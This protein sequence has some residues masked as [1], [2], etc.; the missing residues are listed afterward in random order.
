[1][2]I[3]TRPSPM[4]RK[5]F[6]PLSVPPLVTAMPQSRAESVPTCWRRY[7]LLTEIEF[8][9]RTLDDAEELPAIAR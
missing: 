1:M 8:R 7:L 9:F 4:N 5:R 3:N 2:P 6:A